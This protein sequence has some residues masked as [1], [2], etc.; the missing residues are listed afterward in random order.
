MIVVPYSS[1]G[2]PLRLMKH[3]TTEDV[4]D[5]HPQT[6]TDRVDGPDWWGRKCR[7]TEQG[8]FS[9]PQWLSLLLVAL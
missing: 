6:S 8:T 9:L 3:D 1:A 5:G 4:G 2:R 7:S